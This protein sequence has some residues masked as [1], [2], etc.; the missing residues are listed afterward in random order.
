M[1]AR[2]ETEFLQR[3][4]IEL[5]DDWLR[6]SD[7]AG[8]PG[9][10]EITPVGVLGVAL[11]RRKLMLVKAAARDIGVK[12]PAIRRT[13]A[14]APAIGAAKAGER[15]YAGTALVIDDG[16]WIAARL[17]WRAGLGDEAR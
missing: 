17:A 1:A 11:F 3:L 5:K 14:I 12:L 9:P 16:I 2:G 8:V 13:A 4:E 15:T 10:V 6:R 7:E